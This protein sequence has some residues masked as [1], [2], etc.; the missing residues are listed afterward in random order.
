M[1]FGP[2]RNYLMPHAAEQ[3]PRFREEVARLSRSGL[4]LLGAVE[5]VVGISGSGRLW[6]M[7]VLVLIGVLTT[8]LAWSRW[9]QTRARSLAWVSGLLGAMVLPWRPQAEAEVYAATALTV[10][11]MTAVAAVPLRPIQTLLLALITAAAH[12]SP[13]YVLMLT[14]VSTALTAVLYDQRYSTYRAHQE[15][16]RVSEILASA[17]SRVL[18]SEN[19]ASIGKLAAALMHELNTPIGTLKSSVDTLVVLGLKT[20]DAPAAE[21]QRLIRLQAEL[22]R[23]VGESA[24]RLQ[25]VLTRLRRFSHLAEAEIQPANLNDLLSNVAI[26]LEEQ[27]RGSV[28]LKFQMQP[29]PVLSCRP[30]LLTAAFSDLVSNA[31][32]AVDGDGSI[33]ITTQHKDSNIEIT[34]QDNGRGMRA[35]EIETAFDPGFKVTEGRVASGNWSLFG[36]RQIVFQHCGDIRIESREGQGTTVTVTLPC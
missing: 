4:K 25:Q 34:I 21:R 19:A 23:S 14:S 30:Q 35:D 9:S 6:H 15:A 17:Q 5:I 29:V 26:L 27:L 31:I 1:D 2:L 22:R 16:L 36:S 28:Q 8:A 24:D 12:I 3:D 13:L 11:L 32:D 20:A 18:L 7:P 10:I 33:L